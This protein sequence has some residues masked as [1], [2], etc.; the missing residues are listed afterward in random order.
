[1]TD[2]DTGTTPFPDP[3]Q[4]TLA[5]NA[6]VIRKSTSA[7][8][9][10][11]KWRVFAD[12]RTA[13]LFIDQTGA[14]PPVLFSAYIGEFYS[15]TPNDQNGFC[16]IARQ[17]ENDSQTYRENLPVVVTLGTSW[18]GH[19]LGGSVAGL[20][21]SVAFT[22]IGGVLARVASNINPG[23]SYDDVLGGYG[24][25][26]N[27]ADGAILLAPCL[28]MTYETSQYALRG[29]LRGLFQFCHP[30]AGVNDGDTIAGMGDLAGR[31][32]MLCKRVYTRN[33]SSGV[34]DTWYVSGAIAVELS[35]PAS[36]P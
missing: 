26:P 12:D 23:N 5:E 28:M 1:M 25:L 17:H 14:N 3:S 32:F 24:P 4:V 30:A 6:L 29:H 36:T 34:G 33:M 13:I 10:A 9:T 2:V 31:S 8:T 22:K 18:L 35:Q 21:S 7:D 20:A 11:R 27:P 19:Y 15:Y 16:L